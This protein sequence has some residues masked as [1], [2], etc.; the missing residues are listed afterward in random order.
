[1]T[2]A[3]ITIRDV[4]R[5]ARVGVSTVS[6]VLNGSGYAS[7]EARDRVMTAV[8]RLGYRP[9]LA[10]RGLRRAR[11]MTLGLLLPDLANPVFLSLLRGAEHAA[12]QH[13]FSL[14]ICNA[15]NSASVQALQMARL[16]EHRVDGL[17]LGGVVLT[18][19]DLRAFIEA[20][21][22]TAPPALIDGD[23]VVIPRTVPEGA[24]SL[25]AFRYLIAL[26][27]R[28]I[29]MIGRGGASPDT[30]RIIPLRLRMYQRAL[31]DAGIGH[32]PDLV[33]GAEGAGEFRA[34]VRRLMALP[35]PPTAWVAASH[36]LTASLL[37]GLNELGLHIPDDA[38]LIAFGD[39]EWALAHRPPLS[40][41]R[42]D[43]YA[44]WRAWTEHLIA[45]IEQCPER[46]S[47]PTFESEFVLRGSCAPPRTPA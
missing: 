6:R 5:E 38:S 24:A 27:H 4:A 23:R 45:T 25:E 13:G 41:V 21:I 20:G 28:R 46:P 17:L 43:Y 3:L 35:D 16:Y 26:G 37:I 9:S 1:M 31:T 34:L 15:E 8:D 47:V 7:P 10:A 18:P 42:H 14:L 39:S 22:P 12:Q 19:G 40:V 2:S 29:A 36:G 44:E 30:P 32:D 33:T 11:T